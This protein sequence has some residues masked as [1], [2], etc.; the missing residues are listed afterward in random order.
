MDRVYYLAIFYKLICI[1]DWLNP[2][3]YS[4]WKFQNTEKA[5]DAKKKKNH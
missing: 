5:P 4:L 3:S 2:G 1:I